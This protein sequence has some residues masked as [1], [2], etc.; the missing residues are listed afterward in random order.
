MVVPK[1]HYSLIH[2]S[3][4]L[5]FVFCSSLLISSGTIYVNFVSPAIHDLTLDGA[6]R[7]G[8]LPV[9]GV[10][11]LTTFNNPLAPNAPLDFTV[12]TFQCKNGAN[13]LLLAGDKFT[14]TGLTSGSVPAL[15]TVSGEFV[16][17]SST[18]LAYHLTVTTT[19]Y[20]QWGT[21][22]AVEN[23]AFVMN[24]KLSGVTGALSIQSTP[25][26]PTYTPSVKL[27]QT[28]H[29]VVYT[30][31]SVTVGDKAQLEVS[32]ASMTV[33][34]RNFVLFIHESVQLIHRLSL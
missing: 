31:D 10:T 21:S 34:V 3:L 24:G 13:V 7:N 26:A 33:A 14:A 6:G 16:A 27:H 4:T 25:A 23:A 28:A 29:H 8:A 22:L 32:E 9:D 11:T 12:T 20:V 2:Y 15:F 30:L 5:F 18:T 17:S 19:G 1:V